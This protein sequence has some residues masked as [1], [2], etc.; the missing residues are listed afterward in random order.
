MTFP[1]HR[2]VLLILT[3]ALFAAAVVPA[4]HGQETPAAAVWDVTRR[5]LIDPTTY[6]PAIIAHEAILRDWK[7]SQVLFAHGWVEANHRFTISGRPNDVPVSYDAGRRLIR[8]DALAILGYSALNNLGAGIGER[9]LV[10]KYPH[11]RKLVRA[12]SWIERIGYASLIT[13]RN[14]A[15]HLRQAKVN[16]RLAREHGFISP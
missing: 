6:A 1:M 10:A 15:D 8:R 11:R 13:Y 12:L 7:T 14:T 3:C 4:A 5:V 2:S 9:L 16:R